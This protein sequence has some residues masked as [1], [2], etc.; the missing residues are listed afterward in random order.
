MR[1]FVFL[2]VYVVLVTDEDAPQL[3]ESPTE[4]THKRYT[5]KLH[6]YVVTVRSV[7]N[8][9]GAHGYHTVVEVEGSL[10][11]K[12]AVVSWP[13]LTF[14]RDFKPRG[15]KLRIKTRYERLREADPLV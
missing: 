8:F 14:L 12:K 10:T 15:R 13:A 5:S 6:G 9:R 2:G 3:Q 4:I 11:D 7:R 1:G